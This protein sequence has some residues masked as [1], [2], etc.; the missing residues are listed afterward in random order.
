MRNDSDNDDAAAGSKA[1]TA[2][3]R[4]T[5][6]GIENDRWENDFYN[7]EAEDDTAKRLIK[8][9]GKD[10][11][12][13]SKEEF[14]REFGRF[15]GGAGRVNNNGAGGRQ[16]QRFPEKDSYCPR[17]SWMFNEKRERNSA[18]SHARRDDDKF[19][20]N[21]RDDGFERKPQRSNEYQSNRRN[22]DRRAGYHGD[23][24]AG[25]RQS[26][27]RQK[28]FPPLEP[29][30]NRHT[31]CPPAPPAKSY[32]DITDTKEKRHP[33]APPPADYSRIKNRS[34]GAGRDSWSN[35]DGDNYRHPLAPPPSEY[36]LRHRREE[37]RERRKNQVGPLPS[38]SDPIFK[39]SPCGTLFGP[40]RKL[41]RRPKRNNQNAPASHER[42]SRVSSAA[43]TVPTSGVNVTAGASGTA[44]VAEM[45]PVLAGSNQ[46][47]S[48]PIHPSQ[49]QI[50]VATQHEQPLLQ[51]RFLILTLK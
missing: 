37:E 9:Y 11:R 8:R 25:H 2:Q 47:A 40:A 10:I 36:Y 12:K 39:P 51:V 1:P 5:R 44:A 20:K 23:E 43:T 48:A 16:P 45:N 19:Y 18:S 24:R 4:I 17:Q 26:Y 31:P 42:Q 34:N 49:N 15:N 41:F 21:A 27:D 50:P 7:G 13:L 29:P 14:E 6:P 32:N 30:K 28:D 38:I 46:Y 33:L 35:R 3:P 22:N